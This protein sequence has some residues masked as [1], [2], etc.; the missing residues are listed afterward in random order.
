MPSDALTQFLARI[1]ELNRNLVA[2]ETGGRTGDRS[3]IHMRAIRHEITEYERAV[4][5]LIPRRRDAH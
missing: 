2:Y 5:A 1:A 4:I 3:H